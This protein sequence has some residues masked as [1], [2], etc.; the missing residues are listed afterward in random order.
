MRAVF[1]SNLTNV[2]RFQ[3]GIVRVEK[4]GAVE[5]CLQLVMGDPGLGKTKTLAW[6]ASQ[7]DAVVHLRG[8]AKYTYARLMRDLVTAL[9]E[10]PKFRA[11][12]NFDI[13]LLRF[14][15]GEHKLIVD[16]IEHL[17]PDRNCIEALRD[18]SD[19]TDTH[20]IMGG[21]TGADR[22]LKRYDMVYD[23][24]GDVSEFHALTLEDVTEVCTTIMEQTSASPDLIATMHQRT[25]GSLRGLMKAIAEVERYGRRQGIEIVTEAKM[26]IASLTSDGKSR[27]GRSAAA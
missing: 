18:I 6:Y 14:A 20:V 10:T 24:L 17:L 5:A 7:N 8:K 25:G 1:V 13:A 23:R 15:K 9:G 11:A 27:A 22:A 12:D 21:M 3:S 2:K 16:E 19:M 4:R 26:P